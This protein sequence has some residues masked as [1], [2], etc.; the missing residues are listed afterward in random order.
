M[1]KDI[2][3]PIDV[4]AKFD[5]KANYFYLFACV[6]DNVNR[7]GICDLSIRSLSEVSNLSVKVV[8]NSID[9]MIKKKL[10][11]LAS[12][13]TTGA[14][15]RAQRDTV[16]TI[17]NTD[18][19][20]ATFFEKGTAKGTVFTF[21]KLWDLYKKKEG[22]KLK[23]KNKWDTFDEE[24]KAKV[25][26]FVPKYVA[27]T[28]YKYR[29][30]LSTFLNR[31]TWE[32]ETISAGGECISVNSFNA[33]LLVDGESSLFHQFVERFNIII[34]GSK[35]P[36]VDLINGLTDERRVW[37]NIAYCLKFDKIK[38]V[39]EKVLKSPRLNGTKGFT[40]SYDFI[41]NPKNFQQI[42]EGVYDE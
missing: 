28:E 7:K 1:R 27:L 21:E 35:I 37:F 17:C 13:G 4:L 10:I 20:S 26:E 39:M 25:F 22:P 19:Y 33:K 9:F 32:N 8:R 12:N 11:K 30:M 41:F 34:K 23:L 3:V 24:T 6:L 16:I 29:Q 18:S 15:Q 36:P 5:G 31:R 42:Y 14:Q 2:S 38:L 40:A